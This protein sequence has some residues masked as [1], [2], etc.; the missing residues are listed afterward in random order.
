VVLGSRPI[1]GH[2]GLQEGH[3]VL[4]ARAR[5]KFLSEAPSRPQG[6]RENGGKIEKKEL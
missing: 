2:W 6:I 4:N 3:Q 1:A 5:T